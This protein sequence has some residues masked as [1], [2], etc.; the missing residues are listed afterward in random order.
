MDYTTVTLQ[1]FFIIKQKENPE[2]K[3][4]WSNSCHP[5]SVEQIYLKNSSQI[6]RVDYQTKEIRY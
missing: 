4:I 5:T 6:K 3:G 2:D 1:K